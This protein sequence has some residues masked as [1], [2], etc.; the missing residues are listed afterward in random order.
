MVHWID[1]RDPGAFLINLRRSMCHLVDEPRATREATISSVLPQALREQ[2][3]QQ[4]ASRRER[5]PES[6]RAWP[7]EWQRV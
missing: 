1:R 4:R 7:L 2:V 3:P 5:V 6:S